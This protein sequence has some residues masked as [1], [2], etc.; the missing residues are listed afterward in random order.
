MQVLMRYVCRYF[1]STDDASVL[2]EARDIGLDVFW[3]AEARYIY[4]E[5]DWQRERERERDR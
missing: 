3:D 1:I 4:W 2:D 5:R